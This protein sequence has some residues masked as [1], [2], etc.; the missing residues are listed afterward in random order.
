MFR[1]AGEL[2]VLRVASCGC[3]GSCAA[4]SLLES[5]TEFGRLA[6]AGGVGVGGGDVHVREAAF[7][8]ELAGFCRGAM[9]ERS[10]LHDYG[11]RSWARQSME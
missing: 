1:E 3:F 10:A 5:L 7:F 6:A 9:E 2:L 11:V 8:G 4:G